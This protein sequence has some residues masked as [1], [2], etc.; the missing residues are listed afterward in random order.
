MYLARAI[1]S[2]FI[3]FGFRVMDRNID[4]QAD[5]SLTAAALLHEELRKHDKEQQ[6]AEEGDSK[7]S[8]LW[9]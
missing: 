5:V 7:P 2:G 8:A 1:F 6:N 3:A 4:P 9:D